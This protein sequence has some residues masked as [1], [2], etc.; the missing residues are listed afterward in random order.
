MSMSSLGPNDA[1]RTWA[2]QPRFQ[3]SLLVHTYCISFSECDGKGFSDVPSDSSTDS[4]LPLC[5]Q[6]FWQEYFFNILREDNGALF[7]LYRT[8]TCPIC[9]ILPFIKSHRCSPWPWTYIMTHS[10]SQLSSLWHVLFDVEINGMN[11]QKPCCSQNMCRAFLRCVFFDAAST[12]R[13]Q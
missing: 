5:V 11:V 3:Q 7:Q 8:Y 1:R 9:S 6:L 2:L 4:V 13:V 10:P 12:W